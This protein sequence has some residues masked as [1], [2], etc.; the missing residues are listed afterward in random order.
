V[1][2]GGL[3]EGRKISGV[4]EEI[5]M[6]NISLLQRSHWCFLEQRRAIG[7]EMLLHTQESPTSIGLNASNTLHRP[8]LTL[9]IS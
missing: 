9:Q 1:G 2:I 7:V 3:E 4:A 8:Y 5:T 6:A